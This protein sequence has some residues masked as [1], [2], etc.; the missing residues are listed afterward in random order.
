MVVHHDIRT[1]PLHEISAISRCAVITVPAPRALASWTSMKLVPP[2]LAVTTTVGLEVQGAPASCRHCTWSSNDG[3]RASLPNDNEK[4][5]SDC[6][7][8]RHT[9]RAHPARCP[10]PPNR[11]S[12]RSLRPLRRPPC[13]CQRS[14]RNT[15]SLRK[16]V[17]P[18][19]RSQDSHYCQT[20]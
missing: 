17:P 1:E 18:S 12:S 10:T 6:R 14:P 13:L 19:Q 9:G 4:G 16:R 11:T 5:L 15:R 3:N 8:P 20:L 7:S 2:W